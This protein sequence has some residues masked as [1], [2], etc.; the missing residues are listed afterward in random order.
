MTN[1]YPG[2]V[3][4]AQKCKAPRASAAGNTPEFSE[5]QGIK[6]IEQI[7]QRLNLMYEVSRTAASSQQL[8]QLIKQITLMTQCTL[9][10]SASSVLL[11]D[12][13]GDLIFEVAD[14]QVGKQLRRTKLG[15]QPGVAGWVA[16][17][18]K[19]VVVNDVNQDQRFSTLI[20]TVTGFNTKSIICAPLVVHERVIGVIEVLNKLDGTNFSDH[21][22]ETLMSVAATVAMNINN[23]R[24][25]QTI[26]DSYKTTIRV[27][28]ATVDARDPYAYGHSQR[29]SEYVLLAAN[30]MP[31]PRDER[32]VIET[33]AALHDIGK[34][35]IPESILVKRGSLTDE[36]WKMMRKHPVIGS[37]ILKSIPFLEKTSKLVLYH[38][39]RYDGRGYPDGLKGETIPVGSRLI[40]V[41]DAFDTMTT[42][43][44][45]QGAST[46][47]DAIERLYRFVR[48]QFCPLAVQ[49][50]VA[51]FARFRLPARSYVTASGTPTG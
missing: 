18:G 22:L 35:Y 15:A 17:H 12:K 24:L 23:T 46:V 26:L 51:G 10:A 29:V 33:A 2:K 41:A 7:R 1:A 38:H 42:Y 36:E 6:E 21:D 48:I 8:S 32:E 40:A 19:A 44:S 25:Y 47:D 11:V 5:G 50:F 39:E 30:A 3:A 13:D 28:A 16:S 45:Y 14:G 4:E 9:N 20:D 34:A 31:L 37:N 49:A 27:L 43:H